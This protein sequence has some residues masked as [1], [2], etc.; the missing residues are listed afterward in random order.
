MTKDGF[1]DLTHRYSVVFGTDNKQA[2]YQSMDG[3]IES[4][5]VCKVLS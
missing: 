2:I 4:Y 3:S 5:R 1:I